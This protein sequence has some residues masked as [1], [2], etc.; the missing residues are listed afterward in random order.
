MAST[1][2]PCI[3]LCWRGRVE[4]DTVHFWLSLVF[5]IFHFMNHFDVQGHIHAAEKY[6]SIIAQLFYGFLKHLIAA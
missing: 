3:R 2:Y 6:A 4:G 5:P 1:T